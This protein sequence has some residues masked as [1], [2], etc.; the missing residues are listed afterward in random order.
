MVEG[1]LS[2]LDGF[3]LGPSRGGR[4]VVD[5]RRGRHDSFTWLGGLTR[6]S[7]DLMSFPY[8]GRVLTTL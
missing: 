5:K 8:L 4:N 7:G 1:L 2:T 6:G 3:L